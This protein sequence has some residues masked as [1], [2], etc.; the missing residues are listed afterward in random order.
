MYHYLYD[1]WY[2]ENYGIFKNIWYTK[3]LYP[4]SKC[5]NNF[6]L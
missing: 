2:I 3:K 6:F 1:F 4:L 5:L